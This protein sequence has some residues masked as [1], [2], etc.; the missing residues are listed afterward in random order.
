MSFFSRG[1]NGRGVN[2]GANRGNNWQRGHRRPQ[3]SIHFD[4]DPQELNQ[5]F[6]D[7]FFNLVGHGILQPHT[8]RPPFQPHQNFSGIHVPP[9]VSMQPEPPA[10]DG[11]Q[12]IVHQPVAHHHGWPT[13][14][15][16][17]PPPPPPKNPN[18]Q[19]DHVVSPIQ[20]SHASKRLKTDVPKPELDKGKGVATPSKSSKDSSESVSSHLHLKDNCSHV[21]SEI[22]LK[23]PI[24]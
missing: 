4:V 2:R 19:A 8:E 6:Q 9:H 11:W 15:F 10:N 5:L 18:A 1:N 7:G 12:E 16:P 23:V 13:V 17:L 20:S 21:I 24:N 22:H 14:S 3:F